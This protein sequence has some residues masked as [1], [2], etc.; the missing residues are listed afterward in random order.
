MIKLEEKERNLYQ[1][2]KFLESLP[3]YSEKDNRGN[4]KGSFNKDKKDCNLI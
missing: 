3:L 2:D 1:E 4:S